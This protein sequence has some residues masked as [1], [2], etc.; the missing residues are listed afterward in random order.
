[1]AETY[2]AHHM[3]PVA[4]LFENAPTVILSHYIFDF[5]D[6]NPSLSDCGQ[7]VWHIVYMAVMAKKN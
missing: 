4:S 3:A 2:W 7:F 5:K 1:M 6:F